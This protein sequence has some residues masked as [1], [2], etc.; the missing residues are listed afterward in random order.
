MIDDLFDEL[1][2]LITAQLD[3]SISNKQGRRLEHLLL[4]SADARQ[5]YRECIEIAL[6]AREKRADNCG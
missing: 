1:H 3:K 2:V 6:W 4:H 5:I